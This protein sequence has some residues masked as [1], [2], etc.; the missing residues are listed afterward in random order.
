[1]GHESDNEKGRVIMRLTLMASAGLALA[2]AA[3][4]DVAASEREGRQ[5][6]FLDEHDLG[7]GK[8]S[9][10][11]VAA[12]HQK[13]LAVQ[14][15]LGVQYRAYW[16]DEKNGRIYCLVEAPSADAAASVH[17]Q[18]HGL[19][20]ARIREVKADAATWKPAPGARLFMDEHHF[21]PG[22]VRAEDV[23]AA[24]RKD[25]AAQGKHGARFLNYWFDEATG[26]VNCLVEARTSAD[27]LATHE[28][29]HG[30][31]PERIE[32]VREGR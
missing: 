27:A 16:L 25:L 1:M 5:K 7:P 6:L 8:A 18:A 20:A 11:A 21:G 4:G 28:E 2:M 17:K 26:T 29:A 15:R 22:K 24:H 23:A 3:N 12:A 14:G 19:V 13:D 31:M 9:A 30:L 32:E 10:A